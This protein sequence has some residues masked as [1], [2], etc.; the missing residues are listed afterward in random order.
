ML[1]VSWNFK[2]ER[3]AFRV[4]SFAELAA[5][6]DVLKSF[7]VVTLSSDE[8]IST[9]EHPLSK[10]VFEAN[11]LGLSGKQVLS[12]SRRQPD[13]TRHD[14]EFVMYVEDLVQI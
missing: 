5:T 11:K 14:I 4:S 12:V 7:R 10:L 1:N 8:I 13:A 6:G 2:K 3:W 9:S